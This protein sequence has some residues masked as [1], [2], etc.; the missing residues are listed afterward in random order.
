MLFTP[1]N[2]RLRFA[3][4]LVLFSIALICLTV[5]L[6]SWLVYRVA[7]DDLEE[8][9]GHELLTLALTASALIDTDLIDLVYRDENGAVSLPEE[10][11]VLR[12]D[13]DRIRQATNLP[14]REN[15]IYIMR[16]VSDF[17][18]TG[19]LEFVVMPDRGP[20]DEYFV[21]NLYKAEAHNRRALAGEP[22]V[23]SVYEDSEGVWISAAAPLYDS[24]DRVVAILQVDRP[25]SFFYARAWDRAVAIAQGALLS[26]AGGIL[27][28]ALFARGLVGPL[29]KIAEAVHAIGDGDLTHR[30]DIRRSDEIGELAEGFNRM[31]TSLQQAEL[32]AAE[33]AAEL[34]TSSRLAA[35][36]TLAA[37][38]AH[39]INNPLAYVRANLS[40]LLNGN[41]PPAGAI[42]EQHQRLDHTEIHEVLAESLEGVD[43]ALA[44]VRDIKG[45]AHAGDRARQS[46]QPNDLLD[47]AVRL[48]S[49]QM[50]DGIE[51]D[52][53]YENV[54]AISCAAQEI[55]QV[56]LNL[57]A[58]A[59]HALQGGGK[60]T[61]ATR[62]EGDCLVV[63]VADDGSGINPHVLN[64]IFDPF[65]TTKMVG[66]GTG[67]G[68]SISYEIV[69]RHGG[70]LLVDSNPGKGT[71]F[72]VRLPYGRT[73]EPA[74]S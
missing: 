43:H 34:A 50:H 74:S 22:S 30:L 72:A 12:D 48:A 21:G 73:P 35:V 14:E 31:S 40:L 20:N 18:E 64:K 5:G 19:Q 47:D 9:L 7:K 49:T 15:P 52:R 67:L 38:V 33:A 68:L 45:F 55:T 57:I 44:I 69:R 62:T 17:A 4:R 29:R 70:D 41:R 63:T 16:A 37:G 26:I 59:C 60:I 32:D 8:S 36:G 3:S 27:L 23:S 61:L 10:F 65:F 2:L 13:L 11:E 51:L 46:A 28:A 54:P 39:E 25:V 1:H 56:I 6:T 42:E 71:T 24:H 58:N 53:Q 66:E